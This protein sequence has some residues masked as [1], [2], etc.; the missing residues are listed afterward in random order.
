MNKTIRWMAIAAALALGAGACGDDDGGD[1]GADASSTT[2]AT[3]TSA[4]PE[5]AAPE[6]TTTTAEPVESSTSAPA[7]ELTASAPGV[8]ETSIK[9]GVAVPDFDALQAAGISNYQG[10]AEVAF[11]AFFDVINES[12]GIYGRQIDP[13]Y[14]SFDFLDP[15]SQDVACTKFAEDEEVFIV[16]YGLLD[17]NNLCLT[18]R[19][20]TMVMTRS[21]QTTDSRE[22]SGDTLWLQLNAL[23]DEKTRIM[24]RALVESGRLEGKTIGILASAT[25]SEGL[26]GKVM[27]EELSGLGYESVLEISTQPGDD[28]VASRAEGE[29]IAERFQSQGVDFVFELIGGGNAP[30]TWADVGFTPQTAHKNLTASVAAAEDSSVL[31][32]AI[33]VGE[34]PEQVMIEDPGFQENCMEVVLEANPG[35]AEEF[36]YVPNADQQAAGEPNW[37]NPV[38]IACDQTMLL[39][40]LGEIAGADLTNETFRAALDELGPV[41]LN[42]YG[43]ASYSSDKWDG[44]DEFYIQEYDAD[45]ETIS[46]VGEAIVVD[47]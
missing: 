24:A 8:T 29:V 18:E 2:A 16:L 39:K 26:D 42:G 45:T 6:E 14:V 23:D 15:V 41:T 13:V 43:E 28:P 38:M 17:A 3:D 10:D 32:G 44:L 11:Q 30:T 19:N 33:S 21:F 7:E 37:V 4:P 20:D 36:S 47:R 34:R 9:V 31:D 40:M 5:T 25:Q 12:G 27:Q 22:A 35:L 46:I 1:G